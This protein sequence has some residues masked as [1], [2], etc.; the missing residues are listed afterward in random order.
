M[1]QFEK[2][3]NRSE[4]NEKMFKMIQ[5]R[6]KQDAEFRERY[7]S[8]VM[9][10]LRTADNGRY[11]EEEPGLWKDNTRKDYFISLSEIS[12]NIDPTGTIYDPNFEKKIKID[13]TASTIKFQPT[14]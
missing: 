9:S 7:K 4:I 10:S 6:A 3:L 2:P 5:E 1:E 12:R 8:A 14:F 11:T 13:N